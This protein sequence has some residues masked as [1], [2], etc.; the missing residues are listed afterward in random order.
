MK[1]KS[2]AVAAATLAVLAFS[3]GPTLANDFSASA[4]AKAST[5]YETGYVTTQH[6]GR[7][8]YNHRRGGRNNTGRNVAIGVGAAVLG[9]ILLNQAARA[10]SGP[11]N[12]D[13][14]SY[15]CN[16]GSGQSCRNLNR[17]C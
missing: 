2:L 12:C 9:G 11:T 1:L 3:S 6:R 10:N 5:T 8:H 4:P 14:W 7:G 16:R 17:Y 13:R 15:Q